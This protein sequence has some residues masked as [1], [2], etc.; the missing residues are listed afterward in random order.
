MSSASVLT[1]IEAVFN[2]QGLTQ[3]ADFFDFDH[4]P[5]S[6]AHQSYSI[7]PG[8]VEYDLE[9]CPGMTLFKRDLNAFVAWRPQ[10][11]DDATT[12]RATVLPDEDALI[13]ALRDVTEV[14]NLTAEYA[15]GLTDAIVLQLTVGVAYKL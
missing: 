11:D 3:A 8:A 7:Q 14:H 2:A 6:V 4:M 1:S 5:E 15:E 9:H 12:L 13:A 10:A